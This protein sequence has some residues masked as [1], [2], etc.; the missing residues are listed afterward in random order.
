[1][2]VFKQI[3]SNAQK[4]I[5]GIEGASKENAKILKAGIGKDASTLTRE[6]LN[7]FKN[8]YISAAKA[9]YGN[10]WN[11]ANNLGMTW[12]EFGSDIDNFV[13]TQ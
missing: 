3:G 7:N 1:L 2:Q 9:A 8:D 12:D 10:A 5:N 13:A 6:D 11:L 4:L